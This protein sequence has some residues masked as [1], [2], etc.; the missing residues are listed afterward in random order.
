[1]AAQLPYEAEKESDKESWVWP[2]KAGLC[3]TGPALTRWP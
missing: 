3:P 1:M 2:P